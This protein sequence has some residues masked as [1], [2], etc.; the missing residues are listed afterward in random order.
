VWFAS[1]QVIQE[2]ANAC[3]SK[4]HLDIST[5]KLLTAEIAG[6]FTIFNNS[7][8]TIQRA[9]LLKERYQFSFWD[10]MI[11]ASALETGC[12]TLFS[13]DLQDGQVIDGVL[14]VVNPFRQS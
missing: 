13:E 8:E 7:F 11:I 10:C 3:L 14:N 2:F 5:V 1:T 6:N 4:F 9:L 12:S